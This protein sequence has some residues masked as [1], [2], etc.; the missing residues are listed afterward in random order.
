MIFLVAFN[1]I[2]EL[3]KNVEIYERNREVLL[4]GL[5]KIGL[6]QFASV[7]GAFYIYANV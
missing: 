3:D 1:C 6:D 7:D 4:K 2:N 5:P